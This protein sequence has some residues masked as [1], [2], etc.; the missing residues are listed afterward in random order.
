MKSA[1]ID[2]RRSNASGVFRLIFAKWIPTVL[3]IILAVSVVVFSSGPS[4]LS[5]QENVFLVVGVISSLI[6]LKVSYLLM[7]YRI[8][9]REPYGGSLF[10]SSLIVTAFLIVALVMAGN[11]VK[12]RVA[13]Y[14]NVEMPWMLITVYVIVSLFVFLSS[15]IVHWTL[16]MTQSRKR[17]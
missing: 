13:D 2:L 6:F 9:Y 4:E 5:I 16:A 10:V 12:S 17:S 14:P 1:N 11:I 7:F 8:I 3:V 15:K